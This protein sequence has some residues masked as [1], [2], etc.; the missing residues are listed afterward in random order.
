MR[1]IK[2]YM[3]KQKLYTPKIS[4]WV[5]VSYFATLVRPKLVIPVF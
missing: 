4:Y 5:K 2:K 1:I 3:E